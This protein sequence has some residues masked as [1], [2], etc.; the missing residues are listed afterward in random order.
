MN[1]EEIRD[2]K[3]PICRFGNPVAL[4]AGWPAPALW[5]FKFG[6]TDC[7][8]FELNRNLARESSPDVV[9]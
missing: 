7:A 5:D 3:C 6:R 2:G 4:R 8:S 1:R 9:L